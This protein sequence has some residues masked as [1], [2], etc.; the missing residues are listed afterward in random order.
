MQRVQDRYLS[1]TT[2]RGQCAGRA[3][4]DHSGKW[5]WISVRPL[6]G[7]RWIH[8]GLK[9]YKLMG[10]GDIHG[11]I[12]CEFINFGD[13]H[14]PKPYKFTGIGKIHGLELY[15]FI[16]TSPGGRRG[17]P[18]PLTVPATWCWIKIGG[19]HCARGA[20]TDSCGKPIAM[21][22]CTNSFRQAAGNHTLGFVLAVVTQ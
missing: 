4:D 19:V 18:R 8:H 2:W 11:L 14:G 1:T 9:L 6:W 15:K 20:E 22:V 21:R 12:L 17:T 13:I 10:L 16:A 5:I 3:L 7:R